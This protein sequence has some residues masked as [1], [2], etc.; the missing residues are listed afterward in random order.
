M[1]ETMQNFA[2]NTCATMLD[3]A[4]LYAQDLTQ[5]TAFVIGNEG[6]GL[7]EKLTKAASH[8]SAFPCIK[9]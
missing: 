6:A 1:L 5:L 9:V 2:V 7:G 8:K 3:G 4:S